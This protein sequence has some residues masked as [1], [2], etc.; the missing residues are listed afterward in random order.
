MG[1]DQLGRSD[2]ILVDAGENLSMPPLLWPA[3]PPFV[4]RSEHRVWSALK[5]QLGRTTCSSRT[6]TSPT[7]AATTT[8]HR[9]GARRCGRR[10]GGSE[11]RDRLER[12]R[13]VV[14][15]EPRGRAAVDPITQAMTCKHVL[16]DWVQA[17]NAWAGRTPIRWAHAIALPDIEV[18][19][20]FD[21]PDC[22]RWMVI[23]TTDL[24]DVA[25]R[26]RNILLM[27]DTDRRL[28]EPVTRSP[29]TRR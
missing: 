9:G 7:T 29:F 6:S 20:E 19:P 13:T 12:T 26:L 2:D 24:A 28:S 16:K 11:G 15:E 17:S 18:E 25:N 1:F 8:R 3:E 22:H 27:Q 4:N 5:E 23:D 21:T 14:A 10:R